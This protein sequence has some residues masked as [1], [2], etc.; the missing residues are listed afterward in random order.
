M[1]SKQK[2]Y[3]LIQTLMLYQSSRFGLSQT[4]IRNLSMISFFSKILL[5]HPREHYDNFYDF[6]TFKILQFFYID[7]I[8]RCLYLRKD[9][10]FEDVTVTN[11]S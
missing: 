8:Q 5:I 7:L 11:K 6:Y 4:E 1:V 3:K 2:K 9:K 10:N